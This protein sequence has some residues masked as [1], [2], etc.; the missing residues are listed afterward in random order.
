MN[1]TR[2]G[3]LK[4]FIPGFKKLSRLPENKNVDLKN[5]EPPF[6]PAMLS[7][8]GS[9][10]SMKYFTRKS[11]FAA[12]QDNFEPFSSFQNGKVNNIGYCG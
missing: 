1:A 10:E 4:E 6:T 9:I 8:F 5:R 11:P 2:A 12:L 7:I 3:A